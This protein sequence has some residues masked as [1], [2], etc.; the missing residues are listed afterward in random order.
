MLYNNCFIIIVLLIIVII[1]LIIISNYKKESFIITPSNTLVN[2]PPAYSND[3][4]SLDLL[5]YA[6]KIKTNNVLINEAQ[7]SL[8]NNI[9]IPTVKADKNTLYK[10]YTDNIKTNGLDTN[11]NNIYNSN[12]IDNNMFDTQV[13]ELE[14][15]IIDLENT[16]NNL[17]V[18]NAN[19]K[20]YNK[21]KSLNNGLDIQLVNT[22]N[23]TII[24]DKTGN[25]L[26]GYMVMVNDG[27]LSVGANDYDIYKCDDKN[28]KQIFKMEHILNET[29]Y[30]NNIDVSLPVDN[31]DKTNINYPFAMLKSVNNENCLTNS[32]GSLSVQ[33]C[34]SFIAQR[35][36]PL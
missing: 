21:I 24:D 30:Q 33:P 16:V 12:I 10:E 6:N 15:T 28:I 23:T 1:G 34:Y 7:S 8:I 25:N 18:D 13:K 36:F 32:H 20:T 2:T 26:P 22:P 11:L 19:K 14:N 17:D 4:V 5:W 27:C 31:I 29:A 9:I 35:W 3:D